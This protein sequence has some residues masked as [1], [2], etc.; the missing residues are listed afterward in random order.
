MKKFMADLILFGILSSCTYNTYIVKPDNVEKE[1]KNDEINQ[2]EDTNSFETARDSMINSCNEANDCFFIKK[3]NSQRFMVLVQNYK[4]MNSKTDE[5]S[6]KIADFCSNSLAL[7]IPSLFYIVLVDE[8]IVQKFDCFT[9]EWSK[10]YSID[11]LK[12]KRY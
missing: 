12:N 8:R 9:S 6:R 10:R 4:L 5:I 2:S 7:N 3:G 1:V 11:K